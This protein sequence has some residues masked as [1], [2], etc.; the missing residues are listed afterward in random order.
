LSNIAGTRLKSFIERIERLNDEKAA[1]A[2]DTKEVYEEA[3][4]EGYDTK[5]MRKII[6]LRKKNAAERENEETLLTLYMS[7]IR[8]AV[9]S[10]GD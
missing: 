3:K 7:A 10:N 9:V 6:S 8:E 2:A 5:I 1:I 4:G